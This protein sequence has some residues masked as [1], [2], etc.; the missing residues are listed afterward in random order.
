MSEE[1]APVEDSG[2]AEIDSTIQFNASSMPIGLRDEPSLQTFDSVDKLA[3]SYVNAVKMIGGDPKNLISVPQ[4]GESWDQFYNQI[5]RPD[6]ANGYDFGEDDEG[7]LDDFKEFSHQNNLTQDQADNLLNLFQDLEEDNNANEVKAI[8]DLKVQTTIDLQKDWGK[9]YDG[10]MDFAKRAYAQFGTPQLTE[11]M[12]SSGFGNHPEVIKAFS[13]IGQLLGEES[14]A[15]GSGLS[16][17]Q[18]SPQTAQEEIQARYADKDFSKSYRDNRDPNHKV[19]M[20][21]M[22]RLFKQ[23]YPPQQRVR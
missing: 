4:E 14:L 7:V 13:K 15:V 12:D 17:N 21:T 2:Q 11:A 23:A 9:N 16:R 3:K 6:Q 20:N 8:D 18:M 1:I 19:A 5:G 22:E 10:N